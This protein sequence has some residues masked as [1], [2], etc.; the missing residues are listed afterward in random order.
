MITVIFFIVDLNIRINERR[1]I[2]L[3]VFSTQAFLYFPY[4][5]HPRNPARQLFCSN[6]PKPASGE[7]FLHVVP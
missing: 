7:D 3:S 4:H 6:Y 2:K 1:K 5:I